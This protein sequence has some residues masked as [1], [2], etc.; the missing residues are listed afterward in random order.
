MNEGIMRSMGFGEYMDKVKAGLCGWCGQKINL[1][2]FRDELS[3]KEYSISGLC[4]SCQDKVWPAK[5]V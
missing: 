2:D 4:Q 5:K 1:K 3:R